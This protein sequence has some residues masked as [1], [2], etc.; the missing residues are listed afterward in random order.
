MEQLQK[1]ETIVYGGAFNPPTLAHQAILSACISYAEKNHADVWLLPSGD[2]ADK[3]IA[4]PREVRMA[5]V[6]AMVEDAEVST[7]EARVVS[8]ELDRETLIETYDTVQELQQMHPSRSFTFVFGADSTETMASWKGGEE[9]LET[10]PMLV[11]SRPGSRINPMARLA[12]QL[13]VETPDT[14]STEVRARLAEG[15]DIR[16][17]VGSSVARLL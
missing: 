11:V 1:K 6:E 14:S 13:N 10:L 9:L 3:T 8:S 5:Y 16:H 12:V 4:V 17:L 7:V 15:A 2:R